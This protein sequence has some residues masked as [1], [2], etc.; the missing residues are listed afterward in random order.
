LVKKG[1]GGLTK[2]L[3]F[4]LSEDKKKPKGSE[5]KNK[6]DIVIKIYKKQKERVI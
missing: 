1:W 3:T 4:G 6:D 2:V 5:V